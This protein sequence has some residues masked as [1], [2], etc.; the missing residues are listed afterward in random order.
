MFF[1][2]HNTYTPSRNYK[3]LNKQLENY[4]GISNVIMNF[5]K[6][7]SANKI[8]ELIDSTSST[9]GLYK[10]KVNNQSIFKN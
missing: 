4:L 10:Y 7:L 3:T 9:Q 8:L 5:F 2:F 6:E 1:W